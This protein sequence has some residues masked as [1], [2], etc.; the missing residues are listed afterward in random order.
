MRKKLTTPYIE[1]LKAPATGRLEVAD[2]TCRGL[3]FRLTSNGH[4]SWCFRYRDSTSGRPQ[5]FKLGVFPDLSLKDARAAADKLRVGVSSGSNPAEQKR[6][7]RKEHATQSIAALAAR[8]IEHARRS[9]KSWAEDERL[10]HRHVLPAWTHRRA[11][12]ISRQDVI[13]LVDTLVHAGSPIE[14]NRLQS[15]ISTL[16]SFGLDE[17]SLQMHPSHGLRRRGGRELARKRFLSEPEIQT[18]WNE[19]IHSPCSFRTGQILRMQLLTAC[20]SSEITRLSRS[21]VYDLGSDAWQQNMGR[22]NGRCAHRCTGRAGE[23]G[24]QW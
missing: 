7:A 22:P 9:K 17:G 1:S 23:Y 5:R 4:A 12:Q 18:F 16:F 21:E 3:T 24:D 19:I 11:D 20:R 15:L 2:L 14:A 10:L 8:Y 6:K 13:Q